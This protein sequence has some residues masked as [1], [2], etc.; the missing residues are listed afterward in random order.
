M[1]VTLTPRYLGLTDGKYSVSDVWEWP[2]KVE[3]Q[4]L[5]P[6]DRIT[7]EVPP[8]GVRFFR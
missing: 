8:M 6:D 5:S 1:K 4:T 2:V 7:V 3:E